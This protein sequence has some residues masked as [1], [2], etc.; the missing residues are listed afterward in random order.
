LSARLTKISHGADAAS[1]AGA[2]QP[3]LKKT[4]HADYPLVTYCPIHERRSRI[5][6][7]LP[8][9]RDSTVK[10][11]IEVDRVHKKREVL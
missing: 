5:G 8:D 9:W 11:L 7:L 1:S 4:F 3:R 2:T 6:W 10:D